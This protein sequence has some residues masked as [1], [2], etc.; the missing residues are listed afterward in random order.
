VLFA[1]AIAASVAFVPAADAIRFNFTVYENAD[2]ADVAGLDLWVDVVDGGSYADFTFY[3]DSA[4]SSNVAIVYFE[5]GGAAHGLTDGI[6]QAESAGVDFNPGGTPANPAQASSLIL[7]WDATKQA[8][9]ARPPRAHRG[10]GN[11]GD[12]YLTIRWD[13]DGSSFDDVVNGLGNG[14]FQLAQHITGLPDDDASVWARTGT[15]GDPVPLP[16]SVW[17]LGSGLAMTLSGRFIRR[18]K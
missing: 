11:V 7:D 2:D 12:E 1:L 16:A 8:F 6:I 13:Y 17:L 14:T 4:I 9:G 10:I 3:N 15:P 18:R 5:A